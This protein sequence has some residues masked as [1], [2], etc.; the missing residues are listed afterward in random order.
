MVSRTLKE[1]LLTYK[2]WG[3]LCNLADVIVSLHHLL[4]P[5]S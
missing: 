5:S 3:C 1:S 2:D 4:Y